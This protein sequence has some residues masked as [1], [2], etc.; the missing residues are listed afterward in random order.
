MSN[1]VS[2]KNLNISVAIQSPGWRDI[3][4]PP[5]KTGKKLGLVAWSRQWLRQAIKIGF[6]P[7]WDFYTDSKATLSLV[8]A[9]DETVRELNKNWRGIDKST[10]VLSFP[11]DFP[12]DGALHMENLH[13]GDVILAYET[14]LAEA[15]AQGKTLADHTAHL[16][17]HGGLHL[18]G[19]DHM[20]D[21]EAAQMEMLEIDA[22]KYFRI[23][24]PYE[25]MI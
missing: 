5:P 18:L 10:N 3:D 20:S 4:L 15:Q 2:F 8:F 14:I 23:K 7:E 1:G 21:S 19:Y 13:L 9:D 22:L 16:V 17:M 24:N 25:I 11:S 12:P 6:K